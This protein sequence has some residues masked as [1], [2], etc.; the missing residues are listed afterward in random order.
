MTAPR[1]YSRPSLATAAVLGMIVA[2]GVEAAAGQDVSTDLRRCLAIADS[3]A[4]L[5]CFENTAADREKQPRPDGRGNP[6]DAGAWKLVRSPDPRGGPDAV[7]IMH[8]ADVSRSDPDFAGVMLRC[9]QDGF[10]VLVIVIEPRPP[11]A[12]PRV[13]LGAPGEEAS[14]EAT[15]A[16]PFTALLMPREAA[17]LLEALE[18]STTPEL[19]IELNGETTAVHGFVPLAGLRP[20]LDGLKA[21]CSPR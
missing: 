14:Y 20:A 2:L 7:S 8:T 19:S 5:R 4:R 12:R 15:V 13:R 11:R 10:E 18:R 6:G 3:A 21:S 17:A 9:A 16:P 1:Q